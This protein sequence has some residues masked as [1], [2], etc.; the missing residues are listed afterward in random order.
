MLTSTWVKQFINNMYI[1]LDTNLFNYKKIE[2]LQRRRGCTSSAVVAF[3]AIPEFDSLPLKLNALPS[4]PTS[5]D[6]CDARSQD[7]RSVG[8][9]ST[10]RTR[11]R[12]LM[13][14]QPAAALL[15]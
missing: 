3:G 13:N 4:I 2:L 8:L 7:C 11:E 15:R 1:F 10:Y 9:E 6:N 14:N 12:M 5:P